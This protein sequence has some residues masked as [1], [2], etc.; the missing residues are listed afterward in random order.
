MTNS[1]ENP[2]GGG[3]ETDTPERVRSVEELLDGIV[4]K[5][6][7]QDRLVKVSWDDSL[8]PE[9]REQASKASYDINEELKESFN[10]V[11]QAVDHKTVI[12]TIDRYS[13]RE[14]QD[15]KYNWPEK[16]RSYRRYPEEAREY[17]KRLFEEKRYS[18]VS[19]SGDQWDAGEMTWYMAAKYQR[20]KN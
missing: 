18:V 2:I 16:F 5:G 3:D 9:E 4:E 6:K 15:S 20:E 17:L 11:L 10:D 8:P 7:E 19:T 13:Y 1:L 14:Q 12:A